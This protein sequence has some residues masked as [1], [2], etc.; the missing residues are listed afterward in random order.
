MIVELEEAQIEYTDKYTDEM[1]VED[2]QSE[3]LR[4]WEGGFNLDSPDKL[5]LDINKLEGIK[6]KSKGIVRKTGSWKI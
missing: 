1:F 5:F 4:L 3:L 2:Y 6:R